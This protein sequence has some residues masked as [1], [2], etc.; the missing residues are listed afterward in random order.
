MRTITV[1]LGLL[2]M[3]Y[4]VHAQLVPNGNFENW[5]A[6]S[7]YDDPTG[8]DSPNSTAASL[9]VI[10]VSKE[11]S[12]VQNGS[13]SA[14]LKS[15]SIFGT[16]I[17][18]LITLGDFNIN[19][20][21]FQATI[22]GGAP[23]THK[24]E[25][26]TGFFQYE[27]VFNDEAFIGVILLKQN[28]SNYDTI[29]DG[30][31]TSTSTV[32]TWTPFTVTLNYRSTETPTHLNIIILSSDRNAPQPNSTLY[33]DNLVFTYPASIEETQS[34]YADVYVYDNVLHVV[35]KQTSVFASSVE[36]YSVDGKLLKSVSLD[37]INASPEMSISLALPSA[38]YVAVVRLNNGLTV[39][40]KF[41]IQ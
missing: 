2:L 30:N 34:E 22:T 16:P 20:I 29:A 9:G 10:T 21:T 26:M 1:A 36:V 31:F 14:K 15:G 24:P 13:Y 41:V 12:I 39:N 40:H 33:V 38:V 27:P 17:P 11:S 6:A 7:N 35:S 19:I 32:L 4:V 8:W 23:F 18:G 28:G 3:T 25:T 5:T 37:E